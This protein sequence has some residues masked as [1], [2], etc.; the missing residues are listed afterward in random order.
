VYDFRL[1]SGV[2]AHNAGLREYALPLPL[3]LAG[4][5]RLDDYAPDMGCYEIPPSN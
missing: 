2:Q 3:D 5:S 1:K 4:Q